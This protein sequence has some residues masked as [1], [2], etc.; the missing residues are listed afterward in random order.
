[1]DFLINIFCDSVLAKKSYYF[2]H[3]D[4]D[5]QLQLILPEEQNDMTESF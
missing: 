4:I 1:M 2:Y 5:R 3:A